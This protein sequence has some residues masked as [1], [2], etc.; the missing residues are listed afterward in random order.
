MK[1][2]AGRHY[3]SRSNLDSYLMHAS[4]FTLCA[5]PSQKRGSAFNW[6]SPAVLTVELDPRI[7]SFQLLCCTAWLLFFV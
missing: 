5:D 1:K 6:I 3:L 7:Y 2:I 4:V